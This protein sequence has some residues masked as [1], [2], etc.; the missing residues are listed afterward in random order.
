MNAFKKIKEI[1]FKPEYDI[2][3][4]QNVMV[5]KWSKNDAI[6]SQIQNQVNLEKEQ[7]SDKSHDSVQ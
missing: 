3:Q 7:D 4:I 6:D 5:Y 1:R 2:F